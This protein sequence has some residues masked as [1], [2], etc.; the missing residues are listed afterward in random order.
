MTILDNI[1]LQ[2][3][4]KR[5]DF[6][7]LV[8]VSRHPGLVLHHMGSGTWA[9]D[10]RDPGSVIH[11]MHR[12][13]GWAGIG[14]HGIVTN[15]GTYYTGRPYRHS[16]SH[17]PGA[18]TH[19]GLV[20]FGGLGDTP[21]AAALK[22]IAKVVAWVAI[23]NGFEPDSAG[24]TGHRDHIA[25]ECP[26]KLYP[27]L[28]PLRIRARQIID[29]ARRG[30]VPAA[31]GT[32]PAPPMQIATARAIVNGQERQAL[33]INGRGYI[34]AADLGAKWDAETRTLTI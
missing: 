33:L 9:N 3:N 23:D 8:P 1:G 26:G 32:L 19:F 11:A 21:S 12:R 34:A 27:H 24:L 4:V 15:D 16:G 28:K 25:T 2:I 5:Y 14:Y 29:D 18:N 13:N 10:T 17:S 30:P 7:R 6:T 20:W 31:G 22:T